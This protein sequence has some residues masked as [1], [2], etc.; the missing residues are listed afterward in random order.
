MKISPDF[1]SVLRM[2]R[3]SPVAAATAVLSFQEALARVAATAVLS[4][5]AQP[6]LSCHEAL[7]LSRGA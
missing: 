2:T 3:S 6:M 7:G 5:Q 1:L 4:F